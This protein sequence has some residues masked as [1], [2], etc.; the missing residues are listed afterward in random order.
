MKNI[1]MCFVTLMTEQEKP[2]QEK[3]K[4]EETKTGEKKMS[5]KQK[6][7]LERQKWREE[8]KRIKKEKQDKVKLER[9][10]KE[11]K[12]RLEK[13]KLIVLTKDSNLTK[14]KKFKVK[15]LK[16]QIGE[17][18]KVFGWVHR[19]R[20]QSNK[21]MFVIVRDGTGFVQ[22]VL[23]GDLALT[24][25]AQV[26]HVETCVK[27]YGKIVE[28]ERAVGGIELQA[29]YW[30]VVGQTDTRYESIV[31]KESGV[32]NLLKNRHLVLRGENTSRIIKLRSTVLKCLR[33]H[34][35]SRDYIEVN[36]PT[37]VQ[38]QCE[39][40]STLFKLDYF[41]ETA[42]LTQSSQLYLETLN[43]SYG[44]VFCIAS[45]YR[46]EKSKTR[47]HL[48][49][50]LQVEAECPFIK[51]EDLLTRIEDLVCDTVK[52]ILESPMK[53]EALKMNPDLKVPER[54]FLRMNY[55][56]A[57]EY[58]NK[59]KIYKDDKKN[60]FCLVMTLPKKPEREMTDKIGKPI[61][62]IKFP[63]VM[64]SF[65]MLRS[66]ENEL[67]TDSVDLLM[68]GV[69]EI[70]GGSMRENDLNKLL[71]RYEENGLKDKDYYWYTDQRRFGSAPHGG[72]GL[73]LG[74][75]LCWAFNVR[76]IRD[77]VLYPRTLGRCFP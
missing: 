56:D 30:K 37:L 10:E 75:F 77:V 25:D 74:R 34:Y 51:F 59:N 35:F 71:K 67:L 18:V 14:A 6:K 36:P 72:Y 42:Y 19:I 73:G 1:S 23:A 12:E 76:H 70:V 13:A 48:T 9:M 4:Q 50:F 47:R 15:Y 2:K 61:F 27:I 45:S 63:A 38:T 54:P 44:D 49:E 53:E 55:T 69:G 40:G 17:R 21:L 32:D 7:K 58:C 31:S 3:P 66:K 60:I 46:A 64:K 57:I 22:T 33:D 26:L 28:D 24:Y 41:G 8:Q 16:D 39:G 68:P 11:R 52:R 62:L 43:S 20:K 65:Y 5:K 29:D